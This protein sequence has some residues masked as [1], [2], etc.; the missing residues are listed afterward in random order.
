MGKHES[1][2]APGADITE[3]LNELDA[4]AWRVL[5]NTTLRA[6]VRPLGQTPLEVTQERANEL[7]DGYT[8][9]LQSDAAMLREAFRRAYLYGVEHLQKS[10]H[11]QPGIDN[12]MLDEAVEFH[13]HPV[14]SDAESLKP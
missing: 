1:T 7:L 14:D 4:M 6:L 11:G 2:S 3:R 9:A 12:A 10:L 5:R 8:A 13:S